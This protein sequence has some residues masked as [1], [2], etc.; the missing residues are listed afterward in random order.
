[1]SNLDWLTQ[2]PV[3]HRGLH[4]AKAGVIENTPGA[5]KA[6][7]SY[8]FAIEVDLQISK[9]GEAMVF[10]DPTL[11]RLTTSKGLVSAR[12]AKQLKRV[13]FKDTKDRMWNLEEL[14]QLVQG[15]VPLVIEIK[16]QW[17]NVGPL[18]QR[19]AE[20]LSTYEGP[21]CVM[22]FN[23]HSI[24]A[25]KKLAPTL[26]RGLVAGGFTKG[27]S[28]AHLS[29]WQRFKMRHL[30]YGLEAEVDFIAY[31]VKALPALAPWISH[32]ILRKPL[33][34]W[35]VRTQQDQRTVR[36]WADQMIFEGFVPDNPVLQG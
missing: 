4:D 27:S 3:A 31:H 8:G 1:L 25:I 17:D 22:S 34:S 33:L 23:P 11:E 29:G 15:L 32:T 10:H 24:I 2:R 30:L 6:A 7:L 12:S 18:E 14:L 5:V 35:T 20:V 26:T 19:V 28:W 36:R 21:V 16:S 9:D 13:N